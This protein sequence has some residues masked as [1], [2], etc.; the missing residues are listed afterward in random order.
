M[1]GERRIEIIERLKDVMCWI[2]EGVQQ[3]REGEEMEEDNR[4][5]WG[6]RRPAVVRT[7]RQR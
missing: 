1:P 4:K 6:I 7:W 2:M 5:V 3:E